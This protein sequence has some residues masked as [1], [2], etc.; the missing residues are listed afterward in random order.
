MSF[1]QTERIYRDENGSQ[2]KRLKN[3]LIDPSSLVLKMEKAEGKDA[4][5]QKVIYS[6]MEDALSMN[7]SLYLFFFSMS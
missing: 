7:T 1:F 4:A 6:T 2:A 5:S 3:A